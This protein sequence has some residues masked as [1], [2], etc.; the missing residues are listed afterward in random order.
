MNFQLISL[1]DNSNCVVLKFMKRTIPTCRAFSFYN[2]AKSGCCLLCSS[3][4]QDAHDKT[5]K[6]AYRRVCVS[7]FCSTAVLESGVTSFD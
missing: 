3:A 2:C 7:S 5:Y 6:G 1:D 4:S